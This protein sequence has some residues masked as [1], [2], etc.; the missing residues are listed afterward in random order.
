MSWTTLRRALDLLVDSGAPRP[1]LAFQGGEPMLE[2]PLIGRAVDY[3]DRAL[4]PGRC[5]EYAVTTNGTLV[6]DDVASFLAEHRF[7]LHLSFDGIRAAQDLRAP[8]TFDTLHAL[9]DRLRRRHPSFFRRHVRVVVTL[10]PDN[11]P[12]LAESVGYFLGKSVGE[13]EIAPL[14]D[15]PARSEPG[16]LED[17]HRQFGRIHRATLEHQQETGRVP[18]TLLRRSAGEAPVGECPDRFC[19]LDRG[20]TLAVDVDGRL[21]GCVLLA[22]SLRAPATSGPI[23]TGRANK[24]SSFRRC[25]DCEHLGS[26]TICPVSIAHA[27]DNT[28]P[29]RIPDVQCALQLVALEYRKRV[30]PVAFVWDV[31]RGNA[32][33]PAAIRRVLEGVG[34]TRP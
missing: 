14:I 30:P 6:D 19:D 29:S 20:E 17:L 7:T 10:T 4:P 28:D 31:A 21:H 18:V 22:P 1:R 34:T 24:Y 13:I 27:P 25:G 26:C 16:L 23:F 15:G 9:L 11:L 12:F 33:M 8:G 3:L 32:P 5:A 2:Y